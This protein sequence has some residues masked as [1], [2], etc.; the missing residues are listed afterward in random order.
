[1]KKILFILLAILFLGGCINLEVNVAPSTPPANEVLL[2][3]I[4]DDLEETL[5]KAEGAGFDSAY[6]GA[7][8]DAAIAAHVGR[9]TTVGDPGS[10]AELV[11]EQ[12][13]R[14]ALDAAKTT[15]DTDYEVQLDNEAGLYG[16]LSDVTLFLEDFV[17]DTTPQAAADIDMQG[18]NLDEGGVINLIEQAEADAD[19]AGRGQIWVNTAEPNELWF[20]D[21][22]GTDKQLGIGGATADITDVSV[23]QTELAELEAI[24][25][26]VI[27]AAD[28]TAVAAMSGVNSGDDDTPD[29]GDFGAATD[30]DANGAVAWGNLAEGELTDSTIITDDVKDGEITEA[31]L[32]TSVA[33]GAGE[34]NYVLSYNHAGTNFTWVADATGGNTAW[35]DRDMEV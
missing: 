28:W 27:E 16:V 20:T 14:E 18:F 31:D 1:M 6:S 3:P 30:L 15:A 33:P 23:T 17:D 8:V 22:A 11:S 34:D 4:P 7:Q 12:A 26:T 9:N 35:D 24:G 2:S 13:V 5:E 21:D 29:A 19:A 32:N 10:D 25:S